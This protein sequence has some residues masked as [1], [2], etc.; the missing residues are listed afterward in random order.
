MRLLRIVGVADNPHRRHA[1]VE[2]DAGASQRLEGPQ[3]TVIDRPLRGTIATDVTDARRG[4]RRAARVEVLRE[5]LRGQLV[6]AA[7]QVSM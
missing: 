1:R 6:D 3:R 7:V 4:Q 2:G 5:A